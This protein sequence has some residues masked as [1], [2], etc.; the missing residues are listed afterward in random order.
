VAIQFRW[1]NVENNLCEK[2]IDIDQR[3]IL[4]FKSHYFYILREQLLASFVT[5]VLPLPVLTILVYLGISF[6]LLSA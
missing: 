3:K 2:C 5:N 1:D 4:G 6:K